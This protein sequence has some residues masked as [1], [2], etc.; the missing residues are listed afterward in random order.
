LRVIAD[1]RVGLT[2]DKSRSTVIAA[3][4]LTAVHRTNVISR[5][6]D[7]MVR[8]SV[9]RAVTLSKPPLS[10]EMEHAMALSKR[11]LLTLAGTSLGLAIVRSRR[12]VAAAAIDDLANNEGIFVNKSTFKIVRGMAKGD[13]AAQIAKL[14]ARPA[15]EGAIIFRSGDKLYIVDAVLGGGTMNLRFEG[16]FAPPG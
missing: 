16:A 1:V 4:T 15:T 5:F 10:L 11:S 8:E 6:R 9:S 13:P 3:A 12:A 14:G 2:A 7:R